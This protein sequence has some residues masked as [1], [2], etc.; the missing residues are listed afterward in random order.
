[1]I[2]FDFFSTKKQRDCSEIEKSH[3]YK[4]QTHHWAHSRLFQKVLHVENI[5]KAEESDFQKATIQVFG[6][7]V[8][9][10]G[11]DA[12]EINLLPEER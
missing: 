4:K 11:E 6:S 9:E 12:L 8:I 3:P 1:M 2:V 10:I 7:S 5:Y